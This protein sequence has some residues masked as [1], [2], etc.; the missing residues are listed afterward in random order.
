MLLLVWEAGGQTDFLLEVFFNL[1]VLVQPLFNAV[2]KV[3]PGV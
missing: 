3:A 1:H 2:L